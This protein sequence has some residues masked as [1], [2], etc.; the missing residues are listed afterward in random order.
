MEVGRPFLL[1]GAAAERGERK[2]G[3]Q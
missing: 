1:I 3:E 2:A